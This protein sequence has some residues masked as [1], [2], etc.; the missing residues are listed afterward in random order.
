MRKISLRK[1]KGLQFY[2]IFRD[3]QFIFTMSTYFMKW[4]AAQ[5]K[6]FRKVRQ[7]NY[8]R[9]SSLLQS[10]VWGIDEWKSDRQISMSIYDY[11]RHS[12]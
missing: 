2:F 12:T 3:A 8:N 4:K 5:G 10:T 11:F 9:D 6:L 7:V 1:T